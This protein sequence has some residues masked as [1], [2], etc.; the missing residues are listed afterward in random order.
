MENRETL[1]SQIGQFIEQQSKLYGEDTFW[2]GVA[3]RPV[4]QE[5]TAAPVLRIPAESAAPVRRD[6]SSKE[7]L[8]QFCSDFKDCKNCGLRAGRTNIVF[9]AGSPFAKVMFVGEG[10]GKDEDLKG[11]PFVGAAGQILERM[12]KK[13]GFSRRE[14]YITN[15]VKCRPPQNRNPLEE[16][17]ASCSPLLQKQLSIL[18][19]RFIFCL[20]KVAANTLLKNDAALGSMRKKVHDYNNAKLF[21]T[22]PPAALLREK[23][24]FWHAFD[25]MK[26]FRQAYDKEIGDKPR[27]PEVAK[28]NSIF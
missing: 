22:Y 11:L 28:K 6:L 27:M 3:A 24:L 4:E 21:V 9:G 13:M 23:S 7:L 14:V 12:L 17:I 18:K 1:L 15:I 20:G 10:P 16:E 19:P 2:L 8:E 25:D 5:A 26:L